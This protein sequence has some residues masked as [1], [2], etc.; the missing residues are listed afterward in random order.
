MTI[1]LE[2]TQNEYLIKVPLDVDISVLQSLIDDIRFFE[3]K[4]RA[5][6][7]EQDIQTLSKLV[8]SNWPSDIKSK[9][10]SLEE[11]KDLDL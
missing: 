3:A 5:A 2:R 7:S 10:K 9:L 11:F 8:K 1:N 4:S 6:A